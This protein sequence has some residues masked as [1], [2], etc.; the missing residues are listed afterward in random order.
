MKSAA[1]K[2]S[3]ITIDDS[4]EGRPKEVKRD[5]LERK[6]ENVKKE[7]PVWRR[8]VTRRRGTWW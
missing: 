2:K 6:R 3:E 4:P 7:K 8:P 1:A 5:L